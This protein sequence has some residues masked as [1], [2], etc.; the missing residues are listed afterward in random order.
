MQICKRQI[1][2]S[3]TIVLV[4]LIVLA[5]VFMPWGCGKKAP[6]EPPTGSRPPRVIDLAY[7]VSG[8]TLALSWRVPPTNPAARIPV[9]GFLIYRSQ[10]P[11]LENACPNCPILFKIIGD[12]PVREAGAGQDGEPAITFTETLDPGYRYIYKVHG[13]SRDGI[14]SKP[15]NVVEFT[16]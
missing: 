12:V 9:T 16:Y 3:A 10:Q 2:S 4:G 7:G 13:Y 14:R 11:L 5:G 1:T 6:P 8:S 15:S